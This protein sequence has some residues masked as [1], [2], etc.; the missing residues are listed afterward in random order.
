MEKRTE[1]TK[2]P[3]PQ[4]KAR[5]FRQSGAPK[6]KKKNMLAQWNGGLAVSPP[7]RWPGGEDEDEEKIQRTAE[8]M[9]LPPPPERRC[10]AGAAKRVANLRVTF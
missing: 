4:S 7:M 6:R 10:R 8:K 2:F 9:C 3:L 5:E 1:S